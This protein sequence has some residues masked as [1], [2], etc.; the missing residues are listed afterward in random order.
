MGKDVGQSRPDM[1][2]YRLFRCLRCNAA[3]DPTTRGEAEVSCPGCGEMYR[4]AYK[5]WREFTL[6]W[7]D[8]TPEQQMLLRARMREV[9]AT[10]VVFVTIAVTGLLVG[11]CA[12]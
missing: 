5:G 2:S 4:A 1:L 9:A 7:R 3:L 8:A 6:R 10:V 12:R 11:T